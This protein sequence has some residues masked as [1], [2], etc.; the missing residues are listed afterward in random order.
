[1]LIWKFLYWIVT[2]RV[3]NYYYY[4]YYLYGGYMPEQYVIAL[5]SV[6]STYAHM[7]LTV[8]PL[9]KKMHNNAI[10]NTL[11]KKLQSHRY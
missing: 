11:T 9:D 6:Y 4:Y 8:P 10:L 3:L 2:I 5:C 1:M 7:R